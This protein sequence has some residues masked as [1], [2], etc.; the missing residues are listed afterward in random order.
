MQVIY[1]MYMYVFVS[2]FI[3]NICFNYK[4]PGNKLNFSFMYSTTVVDDRLIA[5]DL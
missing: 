5:D 2:M 1:L 3:E 4:F